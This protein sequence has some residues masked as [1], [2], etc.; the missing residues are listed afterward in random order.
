M[1]KCGV[2]CTKVIINTYSVPTKPNE[3]NE[4]KLNSFPTWVQKVK[5]EYCF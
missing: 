5:V 3:I 4:V 2:Q 1:S